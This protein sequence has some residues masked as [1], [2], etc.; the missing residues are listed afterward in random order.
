MAA[1][2]PFAKFNRALEIPVFTTSDYLRALVAE[3]WTERETRL[4]F[5]L[6]D[7]LCRRSQHNAPTAHTGG[8]A[9]AGALTDAL[10]SCTTAIAIFS[11]A[12]AQRFCPARR[13][14]G[15]CPWCHA[16]NGGAVMMRSFGAEPWRT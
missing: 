3:D 9:A 14:P 2:Y 5:D 15:A 10:W 13:L 1:V 8:G 7:A 6:C 12:S 16:N 11:P 4:L